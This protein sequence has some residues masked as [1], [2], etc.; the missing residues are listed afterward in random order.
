[1]SVCKSLVVNVAPAAGEPTV[2]LIVLATPEVN[3][4]RPDTM[5]NLADPSPHVFF[6]LTCRPD[7]EDPEGKS[8]CT[9]PCPKLKPSVPELA[10][11]TL[12][13]VRAPAADVVYPMGDPA[14]LRPP[15][16]TAMDTDVVPSLARVTVKVLSAESPAA[17]KSEDALGEPLGALTET[18]A[19][20]TGAGPFRRAVKVV[21]TP[22]VPVVDPISVTVVAGAAVTIKVC[23]FP[24][25]F[26]PAAST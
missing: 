9:K 21:A 17:H 11:V 18:D 3:A 22:V 8:P 4:A 10:A 19:P 15:E 7:S 23:G 6:T 2:R 24:R 25:M 5:A 26:A 1:M 20:P 16:V 14:T 13:E 12:T